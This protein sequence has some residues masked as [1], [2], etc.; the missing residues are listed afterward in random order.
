MHAKA[1]LFS[2]VLTAFIIDRNQ[3]I[4]PTPAQQSAFYQQQSVVLLNQISQQL[5]SLGAQ[6]PDP[7]TSSLPDFTLSPSASDVRVNII[8][9]ISLLLSLTAALLATLIRQWTRDNMRIFQ[10]YS[11]PLKVARIRQYL[12]EGYRRTYMLSL[13]DV[14]PGLVHA[15]L[16]FFLAGLADFLC[17]T[18]KTVGRATLYASACCGALYLIIT[19]APVIDPQSSYRTPYSPVVWYLAR[20]LRIR[21]NGIG[22]T[23]LRGSTM[24]EGQMQFAMKK[25]DARRHRDE[26][27][28][29]W[30]VKNHTSDVQDLEALTLRI[31]GSFDT[32]WGVQVWRDGLRGREVKLYRAIGHL[33]E[34]CSDQGS[35]KDYDEWRVRSRAC[36]ETIAVFVFVMDA[37]IAMIRNLGE[38]LSDIADYGGTHEVAEI[39][40]N[41]SFTIRWTCLSLLSIRKMLDSPQWGAL[42][43][44]EKLVAF[45]PQDGFG[46]TESAR[47]NAQTID[48]QFAAA[49]R[50][51]ERLRDPHEGFDIAREEGRTRER[52]TEILRQN[53]PELTPIWIKLDAWKN[54]KWMHPYPNSNDRSTKS[55]IT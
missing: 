18:Y 48:E 30:L 51:V 7:S 34:T 28:I 32:M 19:V 25:S 24:A 38:L 15:S 17:N 27:A 9:I 3:S 6:I 54:S 55:L 33:F 43:P 40:S 49:C 14:V 20:E 39:S 47:R 35:F 10:R 41:Q 37:D 13:A 8:W 52:I 29:R 26:G 42:N 2:A 16:F 46:F 12:Y 4:Q 50:H 11:D 44:L 36:T 53:E 1:G 21:L 45:H 5:S 23:L 22:F 31:P